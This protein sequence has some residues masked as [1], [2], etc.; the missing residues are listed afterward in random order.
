MNKPV[1]ETKTQRRLIELAIL[2][3]AALYDGVYEINQHRP[4]MR[5]PG[6]YASRSRTMVARRRSASAR[7]YASNP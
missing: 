7:S 1:L 2:R 3:T 6:R 4:M 5:S